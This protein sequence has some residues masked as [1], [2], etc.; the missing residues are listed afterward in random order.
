MIG[1]IFIAC[2]RKTWWTL[3]LRFQFPGITV[4]TNLDVVA[5]REPMF[6][7]LI[8]IVI[9]RKPGIKIKNLLWTLARFEDLRWH[10]G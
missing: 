6:G 9:F 1:S 10:Q 7:W 2:F 3:F 8:F 4:K 5:L